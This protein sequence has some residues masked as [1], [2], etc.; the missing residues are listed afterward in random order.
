MLFGGDAGAG[1]R[2]GG[3]QLDNNGHA[4]DKDHVTLSYIKY[5]N[6]WLHRHL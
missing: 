2:S 1:E 6:S 3:E 5:A 4:F